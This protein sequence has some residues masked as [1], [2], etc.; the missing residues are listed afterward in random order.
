MARTY[1][2]V[3][4]VSER[5]TRS[6]IKT[7]FR[8]KA[9]L[10]HP[11]TV[12]AQTVNLGSYA[13]ERLKATLEQ[14]FRELTEAYEILSDNQKR[15]EYDDF[16]QQ[17]RHTHSSPHHT[18][19]SSQA[20]PQP[21]K[22]A[23]ANFCTACGSRLVKGGC[24]A[25]TRRRDRRALLLSGLVGV[26]WIVIVIVAASNGKP[27]AKTNSPQTQAAVAQS[28]TPPVRQPEAL[29]PIVLPSSAA[30]KKPVVQPLT[31]QFVGVVRNQTANLAADFGIA[32]KDS[33]GVLTGCMVVNEPLYGSGPLSGTVQGSSVSF[34]VSSKSVGELIFN[35]RYEGDALTGTYIVQRPPALDQEGTFTLHRAV[36]DQESSRFGGP[37]L[38]AKSH[39]VSAVSPE[40]QVAT[41]KP[42]TKSEPQAPCPVMVIV[43]SNYYLQINR[44]YPTSYSNEP[45]DVSQ[46]H[47]G[48]RVTVTSRRNG[49][50]F[51]PTYSDGM[52]FDASDLVCPEEP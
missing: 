13:A 47:V 11:D 12:Q 51:H 19:P 8:E 28:P 48:D 49:R 14:D 17:L 40:P 23:P 38:K 52:W 30:P 2:D 29:G 5:A 36:S 43:K 46:Y 25:C 50:Y 22:P 9:K 26:A 35:S 42:M 33:E 45:I 34:M 21:S 4:A 16:L 31:G 3:L 27:G 20:A 41:S 1:Y 24:P 6:A 44:P 15:K 32:V 18:Q 7:A 37:C 39:R 10:A